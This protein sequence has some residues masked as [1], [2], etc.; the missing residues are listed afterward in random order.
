[1][2]Q[3]EIHDEHR[4]LKPAGAEAPD[5]HRHVVEHAEAHPAVGRRMVQAAR[6]VNGHAARAQREPGRLNGAADHQPLAR[7]DL[8]GRVVPHRSAEDRFQRLGPTQRV[9][10]GRRVHA[11]QILE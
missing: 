8:L 4:L 5:G 1:M 7:H 2:M 9:E 6:Q 3:V 10:I 11:Q